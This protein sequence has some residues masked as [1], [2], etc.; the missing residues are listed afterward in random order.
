MANDLVEVQITEEEV[1]ML[2]MSLGIF[3]TM[4]DGKI[5]RRHNRNERGQ[6]LDMEELFFLMDKKFGA[7]TLWR[8]MLV[9]AGCDPDMIAEHIQKATEEEGL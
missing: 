3:I 5:E 1:S 9:S 6:E 8:K 7:M 2:T 4:L